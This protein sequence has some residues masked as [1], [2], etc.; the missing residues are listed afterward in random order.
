MTIPSDLHYSKDHEWLRS[1]GDE[2]VIGITAHAQD[3]LG[4]IVFVELPEMGRELAAGETLGVV[5][6]VKAVS[7]IFSPVAGTVVAINEALNDEPEAINQD[8]YEKGWIIKIKLTDPASIETML[9]AA[10]YEKLLAEEAE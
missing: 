8:P 2:C 3:S 5:E 9:D 6:S 4:D 7:D 10:A 1:T